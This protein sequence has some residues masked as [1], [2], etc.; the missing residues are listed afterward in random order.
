M[1]YG[2]TTYFIL[3]ICHQNSGQNRV[4]H[5]CKKK[6]NNTFSTYETAILIEKHHN[7]SLSRFSEFMVKRSDSKSIFLSMILDSSAVRGVKVI[8]FSIK[9]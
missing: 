8:L 3:T 5:F 1:Y 9:S 2:K 6:N 7:G 4:A